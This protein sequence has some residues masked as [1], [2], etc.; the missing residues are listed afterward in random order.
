MSAEQKQTRKK[1]WNKNELFTFICKQIKIKFIFNK[2]AQV[3]EEE[4]E[5]QQHKKIK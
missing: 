2:K 5:K 1:M 3:E 4:G